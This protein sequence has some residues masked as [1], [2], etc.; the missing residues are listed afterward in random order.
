MMGG[1]TSRFRLYSSWGLSAVEIVKLFAM[2]GLTFAVGFCGIA[3]L[4]F[5]TAPIDLPD[6]LRAHLA[7]MHLPTTTT[8]GLGPICWGILAI[9]LAACAFG[10]PITI[11]GWRAELPPLRLA[12]MQVLVGSVDLLLATAV[13]YSL[14]PAGIGISYWRFANVPLLAIGAGVA[15]HVP[16]GV[17]VIEAIVL[18]L[19]PSG[20]K[21]LLL[22]TLLAFRAIYYLLPLAVAVLLLGGHE[23]FS[24]KEK[25]RTLFDRVGHWGPQLA[26]RLLALACFLSGVILLFSGATPVFHERLQS[27]ERLLPLGVLEASHFLGSIIGVVLLVLA[28]GLQRRLDS[29]YWLTLALLAAGAAVSLMRGF[30]EGAGYLALMLLALAPCRRDFYRKSS[31]FSERFSPQWLVAVIMAMACAVALAMFFYKH[32]EYRN[33]LWWRFAFG[34]NAPRALRALTGAAVVILAITLAHLLRAKHKQ[35][36]PPTQTDIEAAMTIARRWP[37]IYSQLAALGDKSILFNAERTAYLMFAAEGSS[38]ITLGD[39]IAPDRVAEELAWEF[40]ELCDEGGRWPV[41][42][43]VETS[44]LPLYI[45]LGLSVLKLGEEARV[46]LPDFAL[47][48]RSRKSLRHTSTKLEERENCTFEIDELPHSEA[49]LAELESISDSWLAGKNTREKGFSLGFFSRDYV[50]QF[51]LALIRQQGRI[52]A[53]ANVLRS[54]DKEEMSIDLMRFVTDAPNGTM[55]YLFAQLMLR[56]RA[57]GF[58]WFNLGMAP[59]SGVEAH[60]LAPTWNRVAEIVFRHGE[61]FY[62]FQGLRD[63]KDKFDPVWEPK[64]LASPGGFRLPMILTNVATLISGGAK[65]LM[66]K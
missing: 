40:R 60:P 46:P 21:G 47:E 58:R 64:F 34:A 39:P 52:I 10:R 19:V 15:S 26:P 50:R 57:D 35:P 13:M 36:G 63:Y 5:M 2:L 43:Q 62:N 14:L 56:G 61:H 54:G 11:R 30:F 9:Y 6:D 27:I 66:G 8:F 1:T 31:L 53:F 49:L 3:G 55:D 29:A 41:F 20:D 17:G 59:L 18:E 16:G 38:W 65:G 44:R 45:D 37:R 23:L 33:E 42:Y 24:Q 28:R 7:R 32:V 25:V 4:V 51:P 12:L 22:G 48:G